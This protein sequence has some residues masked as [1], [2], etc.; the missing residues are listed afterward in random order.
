M[1]VEDGAIVVGPTSGVPKF[2]LF[3]FAC[4]VRH[5]SSERRRF[6][7]RLPRAACRRVAWVGD[8]RGI[9]HRRVVRAMQNLAFSQPTRRRGTGAAPQARRGFVRS[10]AIVGRATARA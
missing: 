1:H 9:E 3:H 7:R 5:S 6:S 8:A 2:L 4:L 10:I